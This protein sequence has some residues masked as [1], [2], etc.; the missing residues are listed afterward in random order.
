MPRLFERRSAGFALVLVLGVIAFLAMVITGIGSVLRARTRDMA[1][2]QA[3]S[4]A[5]HH[6]RVA[7][8]IAIAH[9]QRSAGPD[10]RWTARA[11][12]LAP[13]GLIQPYLTG[14]WAPGSDDVPRLQT[15]LVNGNH[16]GDPLA[17]TP[18]TAPDPVIAP[19]RDEVMLVGRGTVA[20]PGECVKLLKS[21]LRGVGAVT[22]SF[23]YWI[24]DQGVKT[25]V[26]MWDRSDSVRLDN[27]GMDASAENPPAPG[28]NW[29]DDVGKRARL[30]QLGLARPRSEQ[31]FPGFDPDNFSM[32]GS[33]HRLSKAVSYVQLAM[34]DPIVTPASLRAAF[35]HATTVNRGLWVDSL[36]GDGSWKRDYS[37][38]A[39][40]PELGVRA[41][42]RA[43]P[44]ALGETSARYD[45]QPVRPD[46]ADDG[47]VGYPAFSIG[48]VLTE[49][50][51]RLQCFRRPADSRLWL[52]YEI[53]AELW[54]PYTSTIENRGGGL[55]IRVSRLPGLV[56]SSGENATTVD[57]DRHVMAARLAAGTSW[58]PGEVIR[59]RGGD[60]LA[61]AGASRDVVVEPALWLTPSPLNPG[62]TLDVAAVSSDAPLQVEL[63]VNGALLA[64][65]LPAIEFDAAVVEKPAIDETDGWLVGWGFALDDR[66]A[67]WRDG[68]RV[69]ARDPRG[70]ILTGAIHQ[71]TSSF[72]HRRP[73]ENIEEIVVAGSDTFRAGRRWALFE[74]PRQEVSSLG[75]LQHLIGERPYALGN[76]WGGAGNELFDHAFL[77]TFPRWAAWSPTQPPIFPSAAVDWWSETE[78]AAP[79]LEAVLDGGSAARFAFRR[80]AFNVNS[81]SVL[82]WRSWLAGA[83]IR[84]WSHAGS[85]V[86]TSLENSHFRF[87]Q[88]AQESE[89]DPSAPLAGERIYSASPRLLTNSQVVSLAS[90]TVGL[91][92]QRGRP[93][94]SIAEFLNAGILAQAISTAGINASLLPE[95]AGTPGWLSQ[96]DVFA[97]LASVAGVRSDTFLVRAYGDVANPKTGLVESRIWCEAVLQRLP[98][99][100]VGSVGRR[101]RVTYFRW[102]GQDEV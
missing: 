52:R 84:E 67:R 4:Q 27:A 9:L 77:S 62:M 20:T 18:S 16:G 61:E 98:V 101:F 23:A 91:I 21:P 25:S 46:P 17:V 37:D 79:S 45:L 73:Q 19:S 96:A 47:T 58:A 32:N 24:G 57:L 5:R 41:Y 26:G 31:L 82:A 1:Q 75:G 42:L 95:D 36:R 14:V 100:S 53:Q 74:L 13:T 72:W 40:V 99:S 93:F 76:P 94:A 29:R 92:R 12:I 30:R 33:A 102:L 54:N 22:G 85:L 89:G 44:Q 50:R 34:V 63:R 56:V 43:R 6:A 70:P 48:P 88:S 97:S 59:V 49:C 10:P 15:W 64:R 8:D 81:T 65:Y 38:T 2:Q 11:E 3:R 69:D 71:A 68:G 28:D 87:G 51:L 60:E 55:E 7:L 35:H 39:A 78:S 66:L 86:T 83:R 80:G 90:A